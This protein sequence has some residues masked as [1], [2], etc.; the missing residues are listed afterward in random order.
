[1]GYNAEKQQV[2]AYGLTA[3]MQVIIIFLIL[4]LCGGLTGCWTESLVIFLG[5]GVLRRAT[6]GAHCSTFNKCILYSVIS[7]VLLSL[8]AHFIPLY[9]DAHHS[10]IEILYWVC[11]M[12]YVL[13]GW[14]IYRKA[15]VDSPQRP[16]K[17]ADKIKRLRKNCFTVMLLYGVGSIML[18]WWGGLSG[19]Q[20]AMSLCFAAGWQSFTLTNGGS[21][22]ISWMDR[23]EKR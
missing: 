6:G 9:L 2:I 17:N 7:V 1:M 10:S 3:L 4:S 18:C 20:L 16:I 8:S 13:S 19:L 5:V 22:M 14:I 23:W 11:C 21:C 15:P 12:I